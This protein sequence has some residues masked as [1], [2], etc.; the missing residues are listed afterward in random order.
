MKKSKGHSIVLL[1]LFSI[2]ISACYEP[3]EGCLDPDATN[4]DVDADDSCDDC[5]NLPTFSILM[6]Y[7]VDGESYTDGDTF[8]V[9]SQ[10]L[11]IEDFHF[12]ISDIQLIDSEGNEIPYEDQF[13]LFD[14]SG[15]S[16]LVTEDFKYFSSSQFRGTLEDLRYDG[17]V[18][19]IQFSVGLEDRINSYD[20]D[21]LDINTEL[22]KVPDEFYLS[23]TLGYEFYSFQ[24]RDTMDN[25]VQTSENNA[26]PLIDVSVDLEG[27][28]I[29]RGFNGDINLFIDFGLL[30]DGINLTIMSEEEILNI[31]KNNFSIAY[32]KR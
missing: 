3:V 9:S 7:L 23:E 13:L 28:M 2:L 21:S 6:S 27:E 17:L 18:D 8:R 14:E 12:F 32:G 4:Y 20:K 26:F 5:C 30:F 11:M 29:S 10:G 22:S 1:L 19:Q 16:E 25:F 24:I 15:N 31:I